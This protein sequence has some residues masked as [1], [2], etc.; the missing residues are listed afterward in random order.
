MTRTPSHKGAKGGRRRFSSGKRKQLALGGIAAAGLTIGGC[1][2]SLPSD[3][4]FKTVQECTT[5][6]FSEVVC[7]EEFKQAQLLNQ[8]NAPRFDSRAACEA[9]WGVDQCRPNYYQRNSYF[10]PFLTGYL[11]SSALRDVRGYDDYYRYRRNNPAYDPTPLYKDRAGRPVTITPGSKTVT[12]VN[13][14][15]RTA[16]RGG[17]GGS[18]SRRGSYGG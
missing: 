16:A 11:V 7:E 1:S 15:T 18:G 13:V 12:P 4:E 2:E 3:Y 8:E 10:S 14:N 6:G 5:A 9:E 17:F